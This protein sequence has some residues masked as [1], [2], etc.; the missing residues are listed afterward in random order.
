MTEI[1]HLNARFLALQAMI[2]AIDCVAVAFTVPILQGF[3]FDPLHIG[4]TMTLAACAALVAKPLWGFLNDRFAC[5]RQAV[6][7][8]AVAGFVCY[9]LLT[10]SGGSMEL[11]APAV[12]GLNLTIL[13]LMGFVD[14]WAVRLI[15]DGHPLNYGM[16]RS[17]GSCSY[18]LTA[19]VFGLLLERF[20]PRAGYG[21]L[22]VMLALLAVIVSGLPNPRRTESGPRPSLAAGA[23]S[24]ARNRPY[25][26]VL[27]AYFLCT[28]ASCAT[29]SFFSPLITAHG[30]TES[31]VG[32]GLFVQAMS[33]MPV[34]LLYARVKRRTGR[35][36]WQ[37]LAVAMVFYGLKCL[38]LGLAPSYPLVLTAAL[39]QGLSFALITPALVDF[40]LET[41]EPAYL[42]TA[43][44][45]CGALGQSL[46]AIAGNALSGVLA[47]A[48]GVPR[49]LTL[50]SL[51][52]FAG[53]ALILF[54]YRK[55]RKGGPHHA[56]SGL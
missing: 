53:A 18:A 19:V 7:L 54:S 56:V 38:G 21:L 26:V 1:R 30:G 33:E 46:G 10:C 51:A 37:F 45:A 9:V 13:C 39:L 34:M 49:M 16:T 24:L 36:A 43:H 4:L 55:Q 8:G 28:L 5:A 3:G 6:L 47:D 31:F 14:A 17:G 42:S 12:M 48:F 41:V 22:L 23:R 40:V 50:V 29:D 11:V 44:L 15:S 25:L 35:P 27:A 2:T 52:A 20:G 32:F